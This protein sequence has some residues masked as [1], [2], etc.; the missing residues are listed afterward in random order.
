MHPSYPISTPS[1]GKHVHMG[2]GGSGFEKNEDGAA[3][4][5]SEH[6]LDANH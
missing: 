4:T 6:D 5:P 3:A 1:R 2:K